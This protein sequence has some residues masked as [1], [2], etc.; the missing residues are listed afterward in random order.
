METFVKRKK[1]HTQFAVYANK[2]K[3]SKSIIKLL[4]FVFATY[5]Y[6]MNSHFL[7]LVYVMNEVTLL[8][9]ET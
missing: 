2:I 8:F 5:D 7:I 3:Y 4:K 9:K 6:F 1:R